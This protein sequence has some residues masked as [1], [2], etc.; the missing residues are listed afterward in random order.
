M[1]L[2]II[3]FCI[4]VAARV[5]AMD[6]TLT[7]EMDSVSNAYEAEMQ[8]KIDRYE[9]RIEKYNNFF[10]SLV[11]DFV[12][13]QFAGSVGLVNAGCGWEHGKQKKF[14]TDIML[15]FVPKYEKD[16]AF[17]TFTARETYVP[18]TKPLY[19]EKFT[20]QPLACGVFVNSV[21]NSEYWTREPD[22]YPN[23][24]YYRF[25]SKL[26]IHVFV[27]QRYTLNI[28]REK[29][30]MSRSISGMWELSTCDLYLV[31]KAVN[32][33]LPWYEILSL[34]LGVKFCF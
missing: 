19:G 26:R 25:S 12:R 32:K 14:E 34:S 23:G 29:R 15:G 4:L 28:P 17:V 10:N 1:R 21:L 16:A 9:Q 18:W 11:P 13:F 7:V 31:S 8:R 5:M 27:G 6:E 24:N 22:R 2:W 20:F 33:T 3:S 30:F